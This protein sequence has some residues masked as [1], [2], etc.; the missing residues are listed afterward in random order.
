[1][2][3][4]MLSELTKKMRDVLGKSFS[5]PIKENPSV[6]FNA[7]SQKYFLRGSVNYYDFRRIHTLC[8][9]IDK[10]ERSLKASKLLQFENALE[11][12]LQC[13]SNNEKYYDLLGNLEE[14]IEDNHQGDD[15]LPDEDESG[16]AIENTMTFDHI[17]TEL[18][19][20][21]PEYQSLIKKKTQ[22]DELEEKI[23]KADRTQRRTLKQERSELNKSEKGGI[24]S[25]LKKVQSGFEEVAGWYEEDTSHVIPPRLSEDELMDLSIEIESIPKEERTLDQQWIMDAFEKVMNA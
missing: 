4:E 19:E 25:A 1:M 16:I 11:E 10:L 3:R 12:I 21:W 7:L 13:I 8:L 24:L 6:R 20:N 14:T 17:V 9:K 2:L 18:M 22:L 15:D 23:T 5:L